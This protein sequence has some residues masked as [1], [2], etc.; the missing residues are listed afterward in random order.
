MVRISQAGADA[1][2]RVVRKGSATRAYEL[3]APIREAITKLR[4]EDAIELTPD[5]DETLR[6][7]KVIASRAAKDVGREIQYGESD[8]GTLLVWLAEPSRRRR[9]R[10]GDEQG[11]RADV[12]AAQE[13][14][15][16]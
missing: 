1:R 10:R 15:L 2:A 13:E 9:R 12:T 14:M 16:P 7:V 8:E 3:R 5:A 6:Q 11:Q 4:G